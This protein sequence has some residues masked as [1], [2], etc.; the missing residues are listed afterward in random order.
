M[1]VLFDFEAPRPA[2]LLII[3]RLEVREA[4]PDM[5]AATFAAADHLWRVGRISQAYRVLR[6]LTVEAFIGYLEA[7]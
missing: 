5:E 4:H 3:P 1:Q 7:A 2:V 6:T